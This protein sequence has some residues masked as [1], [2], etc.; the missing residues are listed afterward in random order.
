M[1]HL[2]VESNFINLIN[3]GYEPRKEFYKKESLLNFISILIINIMLNS[4]QGENSHRASKN[5]IL[6]VI[7]IVIIGVISFFVYKKVQA[8]SLYGQAA[9]INTAAQSSVA[10]GVEKANPFNVDV[11]PYQGYKNPFQ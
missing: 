7:V 3:G 8:P 6:T 5:I 10:G 9:A 2:A 11:S 1:Y 4:T